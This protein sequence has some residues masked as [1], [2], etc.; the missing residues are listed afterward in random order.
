M[1][2]N[3]TGNPGDTQYPGP[4]PA[5]GA[6]P[7]GALPI[8]TDVPNAS[9][10]NQPFKECLDWIGALSQWMASYGVTLWSSTA[11]YTAG[12]MVQSPSDGNTYR[13]RP[14]YTSTVGIDPAGDFTNWHLWG[15]TQEQVAELLPV[16]NVITTT[17]GI[18]IGG[19]GPATVTNVVMTLVGFAY[20]SKTLVFA[21][22]LPNTGSATITLS[23]DKYFASGVKNVQ[24]TLVSG[25]VTVTGLAAVVVSSNVVSVTGTTGMGGCD[26]YVTLTGQ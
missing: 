20:V 8:D 26:L 2:S 4:L 18:A 23:D 24:L 11:T 10:V 15:L 7:I 14:G 9:S 1:P 22:F 12:Q 5:L 17:T 21:M 19:G 3:Y 13:V 25:T 6:M 16:A